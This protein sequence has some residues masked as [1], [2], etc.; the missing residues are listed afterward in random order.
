M[1]NP[2]ARSALFALADGYVEDYLAL[3]PLTATFAGAAG[4]DDELDDFSPAGRERRADLLSATQRTLAATPEID[5]ADRIAAAALGERL[6]AESAIVAAREDARTF[7]VI[8]SPVMNIR[9]VFE[10]MAAGSAAD[11]DVIVRRFRAVASSLASWRETLED[12]LARGEVTARRHVEGVAAQAE[13]MAQAGW[14]AFAEGVLAASGV[15]AGAAGFSAALDQTRAAYAETARWL[16]ERYLPHASESARVGRER[17]EPWVRYYTGA[18]L[19]LDEVYAWGFE[20]LTQLNERMWEIARDV[21][22]EARRLDEVADVLD[23]DPAYRIEGT[24]QLL[25]RL[26]AF[27]DETVARLDGA[28]FAIDPRIAFCDV[29]LAPEGAAAAPYYIGPSEDLAR[30]GTTWFPTLG[31]TSFTWWRQVSTWYHES[32]PGHHL[33]F[34]TIVV[35]R[36]RLSRYQRLLGW[37]S[38]WAEGW[39]LYA[40]RLMDELGAYDSPGYEL[41]F[42]QGQAL[43]AARVVVDIGLH[44]GLPAPRDFGTL[45]G[46]GDI[47]GRVWEPEWAVATLVERAMETRV[48]AVSEVD[49]YLAIPGQAISYKVGERTWREARAGAQSRLGSGFD[50][51]AFHAYA[52]SLGPLGLDPFAAEMRR[53][54]GAA[55][56]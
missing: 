49:R 30:P 13:A 5:E 22:P 14:G 36:E 54:D 51:P 2:P 19:D 53:W 21:A 48:F 23:R 11:V 47:G 24:E 28:Q 45:E 35:N 10:L 26:R 44:L 42:L 31:E 32:V 40:E 27:T 37:S 18:D 6:A 39:A 4:H 9:Q 20:E 12:A 1:Q 46:V 29:R 3:S 7:G 50:L 33:Q 25:A 41:G 34:G 16:R 17:Y 15:D 8:D 56:S 52:L 43:R 38:G 55:P